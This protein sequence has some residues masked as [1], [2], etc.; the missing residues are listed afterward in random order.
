MSSN[1]ELTAMIRTMMS[2]NQRVEADK[3]WETSSTRK[4][5]IFVLTYVVIVLF[6]HFAE[7]TNPFANAVVPS[8]AFLLSTMTIPFVKKWWIRRHQES[9]PSLDDKD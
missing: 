2:R 1:E 9:L 6:F 7:L 8:L 4:G 3:A 5:L